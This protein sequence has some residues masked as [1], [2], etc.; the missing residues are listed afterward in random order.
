[1]EFEELTSIEKKSCVLLCKKCLEEGE[2]V[3]P[4]FELNIFNEIEYKC[5]KKHILD[6]NDVCFKILDKEIKDHLTYC[7]NENHSGNNEK[8][9]TL[10]CAWCEECGKNI[11]QFDLKTELNNEHNYIL[12]TKNIPNKNYELIMLKKLEKIKSLIDKYNTY[13]PEEKKDINYFIKTYNRNFMNYNL[14]YHEDIINHQTINNLLF[15]SYDDFTDEVFKIF[16]NNLNAKKPLFLYKELLGIKSIDKIKK[17]EF[18]MPLK[19]YEIIMPL[20]SENKDL[21]DKNKIYFC[22]YSLIK[23]EK[24]LLIYDSK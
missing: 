23:D 9:E 13:G 19:D 5:T 11:C 3:I 2:Y 4:S 18:Q 15:N 20:F 6:K 17:T 14:Y 8:R 10:F 16:E 12:Y 21:E 24:G 1:M 22:K 7:N